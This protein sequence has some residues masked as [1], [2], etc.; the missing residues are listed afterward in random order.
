MD[1]PLQGQ[2]TANIQSATDLNW[3][4]VTCKANKKKV[5]TPNNIWMTELQQTSTNRFSPLDNLKV[6]QKKNEP[7]SVKNSVI[8]PINRPRKNSSGTNK[9]PTII[10]GRVVNSA[11]QNS[12]KNKMKTLKV[13]PSKN[14]KYAPKVPIIGDSHLKSV[15]T[16][17]NQLSWH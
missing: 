16:K 2:P 10:N 4:T 3:N 5:L 9:I 12:Y 6:L 1:S 11:I 14:N 15:A 13:K 8:S 7:A 17:I